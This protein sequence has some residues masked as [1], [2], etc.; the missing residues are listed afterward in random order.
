MIT[1]RKIGI[2]AAAAIMLAVAACS[3]EG[4]Y[5]LES[6]PPLDFRTHYNGLTVTF[7]NAVPGTTNIIWD[8]GDSTTVATGDS[9]MHT[10][11]HIGLYLITMK[12][13]LNGSSYAFHTALRVDKASNIKMDDGTFDDWKTVTYPDFL[14]RGK[15]VIDTG[16]IDYDANNVYF[17]VQYVTSDPGSDLDNGIVDLF[18]DSDNSAATGL[19]YKGLGCDYLLEGNVPNWFDPYIFAGSSQSDW[20][21][22]WLSLPGFYTLGYTETSGDT[23]RMEFSVSREL[24]HLTSDEFQFAFTLMNSDWSD[25]GYLADGELNEKI[26][27]LMNKQ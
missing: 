2:Y 24:L 4:K 20:T 12:G 7:V 21:F 23:V 8:F 26:Q 19:T 11:A 25:V 5:S 1:F 13:T 14:L 3:K 17:F 22:N 16:K 18:F 9:V 27:V 15:G 10:Y 6:T